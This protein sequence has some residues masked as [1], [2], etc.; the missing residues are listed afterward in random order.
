[1]NSLNSSAMR[2]Q[3]WGTR[4]SLPRP[5]PATI[6]YGGNTACV[7]VTSAAGT[8]VIIDCGTGVRDLGVALTAAG[9]RPLRGS[10][11]ITHTHWDHIQGLPFF[12]PLFV[13]GNEWDIYAPRG[14]GQ[15]VRE[16]LAG[17]MQYTYFPVSLE[18]MGA[19]I[20][21]HELIEGAFQIDDI[22]VTTHYL[23]H[24]ALTLGYRLEAGGAAVVYACDHEPFSKQPDGPHE[25]FCQGDR[26]H[27]EFLA[28]ADL[29]I[30][31]AQFTGMEYRQKAGWGHS[32]MEYAIAVSRAAGAGRLALTHHDPLRD[33][34]DIDRIVRDL[35]V[36]QKDETP[37]L[38]FFAAADGM[39]VDVVPDG[40]FRLLP[41]AVAKVADVSGMPAVVEHSVLLAVSDPV[42]AGSLADAVLANKLRLFKTADGESALRMAREHSP[43]LVIL[44]RDLPGRDGLGV[45]RALRA[46]TGSGPEDLPIVIVS[47]S[48]D[49]AAGLDAGVTDWLTP[50]VSSTYVR[51]HMQAWI[52][53]SS[54]R[55]KRAPSP[56]DEVRRLAALRKLNLLDT[57]PEERFDRITRI[58]ASVANVPVA[59]I[60]LVDESRQW[61]KSCVGVTTQETSRDAAFCAHVVASRERLLIPDT[62]LDARFADNP[63]VTG[64]PRIRFYAGFPLI[65]SCGSCIGTLC[66]VDT[67]PRQ[68]S[69]ARLLIFQDLANLALQEIQTGITRQFS[70][71]AEV[72]A[73]PASVS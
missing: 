33:D 54:C 63:L 12:A 55:W 72:T 50:P 52:M 2:V 49:R 6:R 16:T 4:G 53:H 22:E 18:E 31:D 26:R 32:S 65:L 68:F 7:Q 37:A 19:N 1:M 23:N 36:A 67:R 61:F 44:A 35:R 56:P 14:L 34:D 3:F 59:F 69:A 17:Q 42:L 10:I 66:F 15:S 11:L 41:A 21:Y 57:A 70:V 29:V 45:C 43:S 47:G 13:P 27:I 24:T 20:R 40:A 5:G 38:E 71:D 48:E 39:I 46:G 73:M 60:S 28:G 30:H 58:A 64:D 25:E 8:M 51:S 9:T 62:L